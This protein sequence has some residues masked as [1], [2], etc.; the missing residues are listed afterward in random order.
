MTLTPFQKYMEVQR[1]RIDV[2]KWCEGEKISRDPGR[3]YIFSWIKINGERFRILYE[4]SKCKK[5][6][7][8]KKCGYKV[9]VE[10]NDYGEV[11]ES[12]DAPA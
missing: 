7:H 6:R 4:T 10:C 3:D 8:W 11:V 9:L 5:C 1:H 12:V 2:D